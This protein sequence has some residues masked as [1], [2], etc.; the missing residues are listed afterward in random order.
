MTGV[1]AYATPGTFTVST[2][3]TSAGGSS[4]A[5]TSMVT[6]A[7]APLALP[8]DYSA[9][10]VSGE[11]HVLP[12]PSA[13]AP[14]PMPAPRSGN[15]M[16]RDAGAPPKRPHSR[17]GPRRAHREDQDEPRHPAGVTDLGPGHRNARMERRQCRRRHRHRHLLLWP[18]EGASSGRPDR[19]PRRARPVVGTETCL[20][21]AGS[22]RVRAER[23]RFGLVD[24]AAAGLCQRTERRGIL[25][26][27]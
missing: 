19:A 7:A 21:L 22:G 20:R 26:E 11:A 23:P 24:G 1:H 16:S 4:A 25:V 9:P 12:S 8:T 3:V 6:V 2:T 14:V 13:T 17:T 18:A 10:V 5:A 15:A 27:C